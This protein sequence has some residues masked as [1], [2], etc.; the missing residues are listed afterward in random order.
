M[1]STSATND[2]SQQPP[3]SLSLSSTI[4]S[5]RPHSTSLLPARK[6]GNCSQPTHTTAL[7]QHLKE[8][9]RFGPQSHSANSVAYHSSQDNKQ[10]CSKFHPDTCIISTSLSKDNELRTECKKVHLTTFSSRCVLVGRKLA[11]SRRG[12]RERRENLPRLDDDD[13]HVV[14]AL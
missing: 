11:R 7:L 5:H 2:A 8:H 4:G 13:F 1:R 3:D 10:V 6:R 9:Q 14:Q 12:R